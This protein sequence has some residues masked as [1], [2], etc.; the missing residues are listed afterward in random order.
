MIVKASLDQLNDIKPREIGMRFLFGGACTVAA[1]LIARHFGPAVGGLFLAFPAIFPASASL[2]EK[3]EKSDK[4]TVGSDGTERGR[5]AAGL[6]AAGTAMGCIGL[7]GFA[8]VVWQALPLQGGRL[9][10][11]RHRWRG[12]RWQ[13]PCGCCACDARMRPIPT[14]A[15]VQRV[16]P[17]DGLWTV[18]GW[19]TVIASI[20]WGDLWTPLGS[21][22]GVRGKEKG[23]AGSRA[24]YLVRCALVDVV[25]GAADA[26]FNR[27]G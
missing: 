16:P 3:H 21:G 23:P 26:I 7:M 5:L 2:I 11:R 27:L 25:E 12:W 15:G 1:Y 14:E 24:L 10:W 18:H 8:L 6:D 4:A 20:D 13:L 19:R 22:G 17:I 9:R